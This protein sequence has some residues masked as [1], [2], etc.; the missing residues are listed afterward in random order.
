MHESKEELAILTKY[1][2]DNA[3]LA[4][5]LTN[6]YKEKHGAYPEDDAALDGFLK[7]E[8]AAD[9]AESGKVESGA[10]P[11]PVP[12]A[13]VCNIL[14]AHIKDKAGFFDAVAMLSKRPISPLGGLE[15]IIVR[16]D[17]AAGS[18]K[19]TYIPTPGESPRIVNPTDKAFRFRKVDRGWSLESL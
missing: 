16:G 4:Q 2:L 15:Q 10:E 19:L 18:A 17:T 7:M 8:Y 13:V 3:T 6:E 14:A 9:R 12:R 11:G 1:C 5:T